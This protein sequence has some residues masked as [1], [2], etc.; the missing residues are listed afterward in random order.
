MQ[1]C[2]TDPGWWCERT[3][4]LTGSP[5]AAEAVDWVARTPLKILTIVVL[6]LLA[7][8][9]ARRLVTRAADRARASA[10]EGARDSE[11][12][13][14]GGRD[15]AANRADA[16]ARTVT[17]VLGSLTTSI[18]VVIAT[19]LI[20]GEL[21]I[22]LGPLLAGAGVAG[23]AL[24]FGAQ[25][26]VRDLLAGLFILIEDQYG[27]GD[28]VDVGPAV[29]TVERLTLRS[30]RLR[31]V[32]GTV[33]H[34]P[35]GEI[36]RAGNKSQRFSRAL[37]DV[38]VNNDADLAKVEEVMRTVAEELSADEAWADR[39]LGEPSMLGVQALDERGTTMRLVVDTEPASQW[40]V[41]RELRRRL[42]GR[43]IAAGVA[44][45]QAA[46]ASST[47]PGGPGGAP[48]T[49]VSPS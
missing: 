1:T 12:S 31:D 23:V 49:G 19:L 9:L 48:P 14:R 15:L 7:N 27:V 3:L 4:D 18:V 26:L 16:R 29:G 47:G 37:I 8:R 13:H 25:S 2:G 6:A 28:V 30:T 35:N 34:V 17:G 39:L 21:N 38:T 40:D 42:R 41:E 45:P 46:I 36:V 11:A 22:N 44:L 24:G 33:W 10:L 5:T 20:L 32:A 43:L